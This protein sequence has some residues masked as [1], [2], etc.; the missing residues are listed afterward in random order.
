MSNTKKEIFL[1]RG[2]RF[3]IDLSE[4][5]KLLISRA[6]LENLQQERPPYDPEIILCGPNS[7]FGELLDEY[8]LD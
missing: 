2:C 6:F 5:I 3:R 4:F 1:R 7:K 8:L